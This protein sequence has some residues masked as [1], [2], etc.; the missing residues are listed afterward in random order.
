MKGY[1]V[2]STSPKL[3]PHHYI[4]FSFIHRPTPF[5]GD[6][7]LLQR[8]QSAYSKPQLR[9]AVCI[10][11]LYTGCYRKTDIISLSN[12]LIVLLNTLYIYI[13]IYIYMYI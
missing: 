7:T 4:G 9:R 5:Q 13:Y 6:F 12:N 8:I 1:S 11:R 10:M 3:E 2:F